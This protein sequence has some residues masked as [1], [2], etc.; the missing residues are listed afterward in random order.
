[1]KK[2]LI[3]L[4]FLSSLLQA[5]IFNLPSSVYL[6][7]GFERNPAKR[8]SSAPYISGDTFRS[9]CDHAFDELKTYLD[10]DLIKPG[11]TIFLV[12]DTLP[13]FFQ[14]I[15]PHIN[16]PIVIVTHNRDESMPGDFASYLNDEKIE[17]WFAQNTDS[18]HPK[19]FTIP[20]GIANSYWPHG[21][22]E[23]IKRQSH[24]PSNRNVLLCASHLN[25]THESRRHLYA[26]FRNKAYC[27]FPGQKPHEQYLL[28]LRKS[29]FV[30]SPRG[31]GLDCH[32]T[33]EALYMGAIP[34]VPSTTIDS[35]Y[36]DLPVIIVQD[37]SVL[38]EDYLNKKWIELSKQS[39][40]IEKIYAEYWFDLIAQA[41]Q[42]A[43]NR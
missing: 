5:R 6:W 13:Y 38:T 16:C 39:F 41:Q 10:V 18:T 7:D 36:A 11:D 21:N 12:A 34:V 29:K 30:L 27:Y 2:I 32:R 20:I 25:L 28:D 24:V 3:S 23:S 26:Y 22:P 1:M 37:W 40:K 43:K 19:L 31:N 4:V 42:R 15:Y 8:I 14:E 9:F 17:A 33:W 35:V